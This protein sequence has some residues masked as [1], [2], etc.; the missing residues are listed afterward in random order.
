MS[1][2]KEFIAMK[3]GVYAKTMVCTGE[4]AEGVILADTE[5]G[6]GFLNEKETEEIA[7]HIVD[8]HNASLSAEKMLA[9]IDDKEL[10]KKV[11]DSCYS[12]ETGFAPP[13]IV[14]RLFCDAL[15]ERMK[16]AAK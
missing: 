10:A 7:Q 2:A 5:E 9:I 6:R 12:D 3:W 13:I 1:N 15:R 16:E 8:V 4:Q 11:E 14:I